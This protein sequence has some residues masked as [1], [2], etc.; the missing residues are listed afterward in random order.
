MTDVLTEQDRL[1]QIKKRIRILKQR[2]EKSKKELF[3][4]RLLPDGR[5]HT[6][7]HIAEGGVD[8]DTLK[9]RIVPDVIIGYVEEKKVAKF[10]GVILD[11]L[12]IETFLR[13]DERFWR[14]PFK[15]SALAHGEYHRK[16]AGNWWRDEAPIIIADI[17]ERL[18]KD[19]NDAWK[20]R[21]DMNTR[22]AQGLIN[23]KM[24]EIISELKS[25]F[26]AE[27]RIYPVDEPAARKAQ[28]AAGPIHIYQNFQIA[29]LVNIKFG[30]STEKI[31]KMQEIVGTG[32]D[33]IYGKRTLN[34]VKAYQKR[35]TALG[36]YEGPE[37]GLWNGATE[38]AYEKY[39][40][41]AGEN[42]EE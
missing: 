30:L 17:L 38:T 22:E 1:R 23:R 12:H 29:A 18:E 41:K 2:P 31:K 21:G 16:V 13:L 4:A 6:P 25:K 36:L 5:I 3:F 20:K 28:L 19:I 37:G 26:K 42:E 7:G 35:L 33:G 8:L 10:K 11:S 40:A 32:I 34:A 27:A 9:V 14:W 39:T 15:T 24:P